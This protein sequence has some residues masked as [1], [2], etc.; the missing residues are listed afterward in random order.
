MD[1]DNILELAKYKVHC[2]KCCGFLY[3]YSYVAAVKHLSRGRGYTES[4][5]NQIV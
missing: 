1:G 5:P 4:R 2:N 3:H